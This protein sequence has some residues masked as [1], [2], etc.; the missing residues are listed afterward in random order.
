M[1]LTSVDLNLLVTL[2]AVLAERHLTRAG[3]RLG[4]NQPTMSQRLARLRRMF[5]DELLM[6]NGREYELTPLAR[7]IREPLRNI[8]DNVERTLQQRPTFDPATDE[9]TFTVAASDYATYLIFQPV[10]RHLQDNAPGI[11]IQV[12]PISPTTRAAVEDGALDLAVL[13]ASIGI[14]LPHEHLFTDRWVAVAW[15]GN[16]QV[17][18]KLPMDRYLSLPHLV[19]GTGF[20]SI[21]MGDRQLV[22]EHPELR[23]TM[24]VPSFFLL[25]FMLTGTRYIALVHERMAERLARSGD[26][27]VVSLDFETAPVEET[28][29]WHPR[30]TADPAHAW[31]RELLRDCTA[32]ME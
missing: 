9:R 7:Q 18:R 30:L 21:A 26:I 3:E 20:E 1:D 11:R 8:L 28:I 22:A 25:P 29:Y 17:G 27:K 6:R 15:S 13:P 2:D 14:D 19:F 10:L 5:D 31:F 23:V 4:V 16:R 24:S 12:L 32:G